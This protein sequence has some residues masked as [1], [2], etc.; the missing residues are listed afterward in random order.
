MTAS[1]WIIAVA[2]F[3]LA[4]VLLILSIRHFLEHGFLLNNEYLYATQK[5]RE[6]MD[7]RP[8][9]RQSAIIFLLLSI[10]FVII[11]LSLVLHNV[12]LELLEIPVLAG[13]ALY[14]IVST[15]RIRKG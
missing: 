9:Y 4:G 12:K 5:E 7:K 8:Y 11:G 15:V 14:A 2:V 6:T 3:I 1:E 10:V 13:I